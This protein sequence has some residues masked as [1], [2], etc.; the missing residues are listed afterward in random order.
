M[1]ISPGGISAQDLPAGDDFRVNTYGGSYQSSPLVSWTGD[2]SFVVVWQSRN[3]DGDGLGAFARRYNS[4]GGPLGDEFRVLEETVGSQSVSDIAATRDGAFLVVWSSRSAPLDDDDE[5]GGQFFDAAGGRV[6]EAFYIPSQVVADQSRGRA[7]ATGVGEAFY[8][9]W[10]DDLADSS[11]RGL[12]GRRFDTAGAAVGGFF[13]VN[14]STLFAQR[15]VDVAQGANGEV[16]IVWLSG[17]LGPSTSAVFGRRFDNRGVPLTGEIQLSDG[18]GLVRNADLAVD[19]SGDFVV[20]WTVGRNAFGRRFDSTGAAEAPSFQVDQATLASVDRFAVAGDGEGNFVVVWDAL[21][22]ADGDDQ[23]IV[24]RRFDANGESVG[25]A[26][27]VNT[28]TT[29][30]QQNPDVAS[31]RFGNFVVSWEGPFGGSNSFRPIARRFATNRISGQVFIDADGDGLRGPTESPLALT[32]VSLLDAAETV[33]RSVE[34]RADGTYSFGVLPS[35]TDLTVRFEPSADW[36][37]TAA[38]AGDDALD[39]DADPATGEAPA[40]QVAAGEIVT[41]VDAGLLPVGGL[42]IDGFESG[43]AGAWDETFP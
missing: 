3:Q 37:F 9:A 8:A 23:G 38:D 6:G 39:S 13:E 24:A 11:Q 1:V 16:L 20:V 15:V 32:R 34:T 25:H 12:R 17:H 2:D 14:T 4:S 40:V 43:D 42:L 33:L 41:G 7:V 31:D 22:D 36:A 21:Y 10:D 28:Y 27:V 26:F 18:T 29:G 5:V 30:R 35:A 19:D